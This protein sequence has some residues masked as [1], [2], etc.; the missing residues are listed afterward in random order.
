MDINPVNAI[1]T[2]KT[3]NYG[4]YLRHKYGGKPLVIRLVSVEGD[5]IRGTD[6][7]REHTVL[8]AD[9]EPFNSKGYR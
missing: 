7:G 9:Y 4:V 3:G 1:T 8:A 6:R 2:G 5:F